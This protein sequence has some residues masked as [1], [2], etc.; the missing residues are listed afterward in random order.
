[1]KQVLQNAKTGAVSVLDVPAPLVQPGHVLVRTA[2]SLISAGTERSSVESAQKNLLA[3]AI[4]QP[5]LVKQACES[6]P[7]AKRFVLHFRDLK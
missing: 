4:E 3:R 7:V 1:M 5:Q 6:R 2:A